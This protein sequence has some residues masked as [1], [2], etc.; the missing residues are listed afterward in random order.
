MPYSSDAIVVGTI[1][2]L[3]VAFVLAILADACCHTPLLA[4]KTSLHFIISDHG[5]R[6]SLLDDGQAAVLISV[7]AIGGVV[8]DLITD[9]A[10]QDVRES[11]S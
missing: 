8:G 3:N 1:F 9:T 11:L 2:N 10:V 6:D 5:A 4:C 7:I